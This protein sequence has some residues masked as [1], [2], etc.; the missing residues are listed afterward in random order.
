MDTLKA[1]G[2]SQL[3]VVTYAGLVGQ[4]TVPPNGFGGTPR[5]QKMLK[6]HLPRVIFHHVYKYT[7]MKDTEKLTCARAARRTMRFSKPQKSVGTWSNVCQK[8]TKINVIAT[9]G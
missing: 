6:G 3:H 5:E 1:I 4:P 7:E 8:G 9:P 2:H